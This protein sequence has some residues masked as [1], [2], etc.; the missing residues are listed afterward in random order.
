MAFFFWDY[1]QRVSP[2]ACRELVPLVC[3]MYGKTLSSHRWN[4]IPCKFIGKFFPVPSPDFPTENARNAVSQEKREREK[5]THTPQR[6][7]RK[8]GGI[9]LA[10]LSRMRKSYL[11]LYI[12][13]PRSV[14]GVGKYSSLTTNP[15]TPYY[16]D[17]D[18]RLRSWSS[19]SRP[20][21]P[22]TCPSRPHSA[23]TPAPGY[24]SPS[25]AC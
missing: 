14:P 25:S 1:R 3:Y 9:H 23:A 6:Q 18:Y 17:E 15:P 16:Q 20:P 7:E 21:A 13:L 5:E 24:C 4:T 2:F 12:F 8:V 22:A 19:A 10:V 11:L